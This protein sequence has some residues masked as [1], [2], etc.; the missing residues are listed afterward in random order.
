MQ[1]LPNVRKSRMEK[2]RR[3]ILEPNRERKKVKA[4]I[5]DFCDLCK[6]AKAQKTPF[7]SGFVRGHEI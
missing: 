2:N 7:V 5:R 4:E 1:F 3:K 6:N